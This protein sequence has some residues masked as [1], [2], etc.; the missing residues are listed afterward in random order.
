M[1]EFALSENSNLNFHYPS[2]SESIIDELALEGQVF[3]HLPIASSVRHLSLDDYLFHEGELKTHV[4]RLETGII[5]VT[6]PRLNGPPEMIETV[7][8]GNLLG[9]GF[10][11]RNIYNAKAVVESR[12]SCWP[13]S[14]IPALVEENATAQRRQAEAT[15]G[16]FAHRRSAMVR[17]TQDH[18]VQRVAA[19]LVAVS[20]LN[21]VEGRDPNVISDKL[22]CGVVAKYL[23]LDIDTLAHALVELEARALVEQSPT[24]GLR[25]CD[26]EKLDGITPTAWQM[27]G[28]G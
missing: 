22:H 16:E 2:V 24:G 5:C 25:L 21:E 7:F 8:P 19:F 20:R 3:D 12:V 4:Y 18:P 15:E 10:L 28:V 27:C 1:V 23:G 9:L 11:K 14:A 26:R 6:A 17:L 13:L